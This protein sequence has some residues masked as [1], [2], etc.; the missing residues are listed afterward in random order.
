MTQEGKKN[1]KKKKNLTNV[2]KKGKEFSNGDKKI[3]QT[4]SFITK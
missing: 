2:P 3:V 4:S 1:K